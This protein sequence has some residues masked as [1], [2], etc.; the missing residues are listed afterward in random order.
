MIQ[1]TL[2]NNEKTRRSMSNDKKVMQITIEDIIERKIQFTI[3]NTI[4][5]KIEFKENDDG[6]LLA[7]HEMLV[8]IKLMSEDAFINKYFETIKKIQRQ[9]DNQ[10]ISENKIEKM[11][12]YNNAIV[13]IL[14]LI[15]P[16]Y[17]YDLDE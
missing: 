4:F 9:F 16:I 6:E 8:D 5:D 2:Q 14:E 10:D 3:T 13:S 1:E 15:N 7:Y 12:G 17:K 11:S